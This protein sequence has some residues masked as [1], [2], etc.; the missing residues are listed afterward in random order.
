[1]T[2]HDHLITVRFDLSHALTEEPQVDG[3][4]YMDCRMHPAHVPSPGDR[5]WLDE[6]D[7][8]SC[9]RDKE[10][11][12]EILRDLWLQAEHDS[13]VFVVDY[14]IMNYTRYIGFNICCVLK[15]L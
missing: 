14:R 6:N 9:V 15:R 12:A 11:R 10:V 2:A 4:Y 1:M 8:C 13:P 7:R 5:I 3:T